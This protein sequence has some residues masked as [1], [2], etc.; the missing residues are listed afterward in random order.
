M[1][2]DMYIEK[3]KK[4]VCYWRKANQIHGWFERTL[5]NGESTNCE[6]LKVTKDNLESLRHV[7]ERILKSSIDKREQLARELL[8]TCEGFFFGSYNYDDSYY[9]Q[10]EN[11]VNMLNL[12]LETWDDNA[13]YEYTCWW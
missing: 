8:P 2:L 9:R 13:L 1:G 11:T 10:L 12:V 6:Y 4:E 3:D 7:C 5:N